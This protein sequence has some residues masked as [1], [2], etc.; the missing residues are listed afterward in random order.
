MP[1]VRRCL[2]L[3]LKENIIKVAGTSMNGKVYAR[4]YTPLLS[5]ENYLK[6]N[7]ES[8]KISPVEMMTALLES[9][10]VTVE[11]IEQLQKLLD[12]K[13]AELENK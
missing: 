5:R 9:D 3:L 8:R 12:K 4:N 6:G 11:E 10:G 1:T 13:R 2:E 7:A